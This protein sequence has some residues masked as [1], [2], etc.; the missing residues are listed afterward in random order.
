[1]FSRERKSLPGITRCVDRA[2]HALG[3]RGVGRATPHQN[4]LVVLVDFSVM[5]FS[6]DDVF[7]CPLCEELQDGQIITSKDTGGFELVPV[8]IPALHR[9]VVTSRALTS[10]VFDLIGKNG[11]GNSMQAE[12]LQRLVCRPVRGRR[13]GGCHT[14]RVKW[15]K[16]GQ[17]AA[18]AVRCPHG[19]RLWWT[20]ATESENNA[21][22][23][24]PCECKGFDVST[25]S[26]VGVHE[27]L[28][29]TL[30]MKNSE[31]RK[32]R[33]RTDCRKLAG[34]QESRLP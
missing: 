12:S 4:L 31:S 34:S 28:L 16:R 20:Q 17:G 19:Y 29:F 27:G 26:F 21:T 14:K 3:D 10:G 18:D 6:G 30:C 32:N 9:Y 25:Q 33:E 7:P 13:F 15:I 24:L 23:A 11:D 8:T 22:S 2:H 5:N 1:M